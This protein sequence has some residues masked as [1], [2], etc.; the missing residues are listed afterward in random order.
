MS[1]TKP[2]KA[3]PKIRKFFNKELMPLAE[4]LQKEGGIFFA[5]GPDPSANTYYIDRP[6]TKVSPADFEV[7]ACNSGN[8]LKSSLIALWA[9]QG[10]PQLSAIAPALCSLVRV[11]HEVEMEEEQKGEISPSMYVLF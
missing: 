10:Y 8:N 6:R 3:V 2:N 7:E 11:C 1:S 9:S 4:S 5:L